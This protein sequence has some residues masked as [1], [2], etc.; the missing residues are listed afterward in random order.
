MASKINAV[1]STIITLILFV[2]IPYI[3]P[4][5][6]PPYLIAQIEQSG[7]DLAS[8]IDQI[9]II[10]ALTATM[11]LVGGLV[12][13]TSLIALLIKVRN[14]SSERLSAFSACFRRSINPLS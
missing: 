5:Y 9:M 13:P 14:F 11:T 12:S 8:F 6:I 4:S 3:L 7:F 1:I 2:G 10:G